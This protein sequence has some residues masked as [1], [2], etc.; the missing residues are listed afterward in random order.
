MLRVRVLNG[1]DL[2]GVNIGV[3]IFTSTDGWYVITLKQKLPVNGIRLVDF[4]NNGKKGI[5]K[6]KE[7]EFYEE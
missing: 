4:L 3:A 7:V 1:V 6:I 2:Q 5:F